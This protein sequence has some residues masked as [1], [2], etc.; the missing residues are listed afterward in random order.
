M[1]RAVACSVLLYRLLLY[2][3]PATFR[4]GFGERMSRVF[5]D[6]CRVT[7]Q[8]SGLPALIPLWFSTLCDVALSAGLERWQASMRVYQ[9]K[10]GTMASMRDIRHFPARLWVA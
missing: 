4:R 8:E 6:H 1:R 9:E 2:A 5:A 7:L 3:Y 10:V